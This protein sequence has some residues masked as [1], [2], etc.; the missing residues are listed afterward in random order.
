MVNTGSSNITIDNVTVKNAITGIDFISCNKVTVE[1]CTLTQN[2]TG[3]QLNSSYDINVID[4]VASANTHAGFDLLSSF[5]NSF[6]NCKALSTGQGNTIAYNNVVTGF[7]STNG[8]G[9]IFERCIA[10]GYTSIINN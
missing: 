9:N 2:T 4:T 3:M 8:Y 1:Q 6:I 5:T 10:N 7:A